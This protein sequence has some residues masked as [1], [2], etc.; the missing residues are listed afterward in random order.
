MSFTQDT[1][2]FQQILLALLVCVI[3]IK[4]IK[5]K[6]AAKNLPPGPTPLPLLGNLWALRF[7]LHP[8]TLRKMAKSYGDIYTLWLGHTPLVVLSGCKSVR[9]GLITHSEEL[10][11]RPV[12]GFMTA[13]T[14][15]RGI[16]T[17][18]GHTWKQQRRFGLMTLRN[19]GLGKRG[20]ESRIQEEAQ[21]LVESLAAKN[22][23]PINPS[24]LIV[25]AV[26]N[27]ISAVVFGHRFSIEDPTFQEMVKCNSSLVSGLGTAWGRMYDA[28]PWLMRYVPGPHQKS[29]AAI[30]YLA[31]FIKKEIKLHEI[32]S[33]KDDPQDMIDY[34]LTQIEKTKHELDTTFDEENMIQVVIDLFIAGTETTAISLQWALLYMVAFPE[35][36]K[37]VQKELDTVL[38]G[39]PLAYY[40]DRKK[41]PFT[42]AVIHE[43]QRYGNI[44]SVGIPRSCIRKVTVNG[45]QLN[46]N[47]IVLPNL[48]SVLHDQRQWETP[49]KFNPNHFLDKNG[50]FCTN[51]A[52][53]PFSAGHRVCLGEQL[54]RFEL[55]IFFTT[56]L[57]RFS[58]ELPKGV[59]EV[60]TDYVFKM[61]LQPHPYEICAIPR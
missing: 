60:N 45:Y 36:Q 22:G 35:I 27:V 37:K 58:I 18:N 31:A 44:A 23:E 6:W 8:K 2:S 13:L 54:A 53:L 48:D 20:L 40:E 15:E 41:L 10:S 50:D 55:F 61:T 38:D 28:F 33:S 1:W 30:D 43:V 34:Y 49:Y 7:K 17:T 11:G 21:C 42:N 24:D 47:T 3:T 51:E 19:L 56:I 12:D 9:N 29:F 26:A 52:F 59:T 46:K 5:M 14:N 16:G 39:S 57:R 32:N 4:Y 25:L